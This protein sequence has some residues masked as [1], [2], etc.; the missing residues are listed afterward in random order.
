MKGRL[1]AGAADEA[2]R[3]C[4]ACRSGH[5]Y[6]LSKSGY[7]MNPCKK[8][9]LYCSAGI[10]ISAPHEDAQTVVPMY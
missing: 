10:S 4:T 9:V 2:S 5:T 6:A 8:W 7:L 3:A 1:E